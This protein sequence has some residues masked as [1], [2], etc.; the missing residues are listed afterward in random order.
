MADIQENRKL[1]Y[2]IAAGRSTWEIPKSPAAPRPAKLHLAL[3]W[4][5]SFKICHKMSGPRAKTRLQITSCQSDSL[6]SLTSKQAFLC[7]R[8]AGF[9][10]RAN[11]RPRDCTPTHFNN[12]PHQ[13]AGS[14]RRAAESSAAKVRRCRRCGERCNAASQ[15]NCS[16][17][18][19]AGKTNLC[20]YNH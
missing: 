14:A 12:T 20:I 4:T 16:S 6:S 9:E 19:E 11:G 13:R 15:A 3:L 7:H 10:F 1:V 2:L 17:R 8:E 5:F 18:K